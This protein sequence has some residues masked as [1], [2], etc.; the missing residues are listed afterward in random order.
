MLTCRSLL[1][2]RT[3][4]DDGIGIPTGREANIIDIVLLSPERHICVW[5]WDTPRLVGAAGG[6][7][8]GEGS[9]RGRR[10]RRKGFQ[11][12][13]S[14]EGQISVHCWSRPC[15]AIF[16]KFFIHHHDVPACFSPW[17]AITAAF[18]RNVC[19]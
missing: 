1:Q 4:A 19:S 8:T 7:L 5:D 10:G 6:V 2:I 16:D 9:E 3:N 12:G 18:C 13:N 14:S 11:Q 17:P 15:Y